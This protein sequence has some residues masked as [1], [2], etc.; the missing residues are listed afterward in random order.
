MTALL[1]MKNGAF[2]A[3]LVLAA[4]PI[5]RSTGQVLIPIPFPS[6]GPEKKP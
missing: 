1:R 4:M 5:E 6:P 3:A 2:G